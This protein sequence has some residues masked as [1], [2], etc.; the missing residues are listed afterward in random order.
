MN[1]FSCSRAHSTSYE[2]SSL[3]LPRFST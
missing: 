2:T 3:A 1:G